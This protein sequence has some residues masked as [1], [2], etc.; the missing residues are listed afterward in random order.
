MDDIVEAPVDEGDVQAV[1]STED[2][3]KESV[4]DEDV[5]LVICDYDGFYIGDKKEDSVN[6][7]ID[8]TINTNETSIEV[9]CYA[10]GSNKLMEADDIT[11]TTER[12]VNSQVVEGVITFH[13]DIS[14]ESQQMTESK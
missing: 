5:V 13:T 9:D 4:D 6:E 3:N 2:L 12:T 14:R 1:D 11:R 7:D 8:K 10:E